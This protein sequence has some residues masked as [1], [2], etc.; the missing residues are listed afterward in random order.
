VLWYL[1]NGCVEEDVERAHLRAPWYRHK[2]EPS[3]GDMLGGLRRHLWAERSFS[4][5]NSHQG[6]SKLVADLEDLLSVA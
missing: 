3:F 1:A 6:S 2:S 4:E 5:P